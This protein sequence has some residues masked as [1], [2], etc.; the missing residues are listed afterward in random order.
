MTNYRILPLALIGALVASSAAY[1][2]QTA[3]GNI[4][5]L[6]PAA[7]QMML[8]NGDRFTA[9]RNVNLRDF[10]VGERVAVTYDQHKNKRVA[11]EVTPGLTADLNTWNTLHQHS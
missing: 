3:E 9:P 10:Y 8:S 4:V 2:A 7:H 5:K 1:A 6:N 11:L